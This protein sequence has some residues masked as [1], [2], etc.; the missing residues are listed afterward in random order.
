MKN[1]TKQLVLTTQSILKFDHFRKKPIID[2][3]ITYIEIR[4]KVRVVP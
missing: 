3:I 2:E 1:S 4:V